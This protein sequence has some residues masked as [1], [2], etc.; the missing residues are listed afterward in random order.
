MFVHRNLD[1]LH[2]F[3]HF[4]AALRLGRFRGL[5]FEAVDEGL[6]MLAPRLLFLGKRGI[7][8][9][10]HGARFLEFVVPAAV[11]RQLAVF[12]MQE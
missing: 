12:E 3:Q 10:L 4:D 7:K 8:R 11:K 2:L 5:G 9:A 1:G 6:Q